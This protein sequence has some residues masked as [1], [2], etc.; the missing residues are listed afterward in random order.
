M[1]GIV[2]ASSSPLFLLHESESTEMCTDIL[3]MNTPKPDKPTS[4]PLK[5]Q[6]TKVENQE[7]PT[8]DSPQ[9]QSLTLNYNIPS[10]N[11]KPGQKPELV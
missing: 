8:S 1:A 7:S 11:L 6:S 3:P 4:A 2:G 9:L 5:P 10:G